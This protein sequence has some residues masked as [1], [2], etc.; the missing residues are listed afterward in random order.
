MST[1][2]ATEK[3]YFEKLFDMRS[4]YVLDFTDNTFE[5]FFRHYGIH[6]HNSKYQIYG[7]S[8]AKKLRA[9]WEME[10]DNTVGRALSEMVNYYE[11]DEPMNH[12]GSH[13]ALIEKCRQIATRLQT[14]G[15]IHTGQSAKLFSN[16]QL[17]TLSLSKPSNGGIVQNSYT[18]IVLGNVHQVAS[19]MNVHQEITTPVKPGDIHSLLYALRELNL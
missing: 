6:I 5:E 9:F 4:G 8:K 13:V 10:D 12:G 14:D 1:L 11:V 7:S 3:R 19:G 2:T 17:E 15:E 18:T 16:Q